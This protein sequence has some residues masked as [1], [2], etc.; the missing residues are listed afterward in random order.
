MQVLT[1]SRDTDGIRS[2]VFAV[3]EDFQIL[4]CFRAYLLEHLTIRCRDIRHLILRDQRQDVQKRCSQFMHLSRYFR[5]MPVIH[6]R[7]QYRV[8][9]DNQSQFRGFADSFD[10]VRDQHF[11]CLYAGMHDIVLIHHKFVDLRFDLRI[12]RI[13][14]NRYRIDSQSRHP[15]YLIRQPVS[16]GGQAA[17][18]LG[19][20]L[21]DQLKGI[22]RIIGRKSIARSGNAD[23]RQFRTQLFGSS[24]NI[25]AFLGLQY[26]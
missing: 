12:D 16:V 21:F 7:Y 3:T 6:S 2:A 19:I 15:F 8:D 9:L 24:D 10:L 11:C 5:Y 23:H 18:H 14:R 20:F 4:S 13:D 17:Y 26:K 25:D 22:Q 1:A